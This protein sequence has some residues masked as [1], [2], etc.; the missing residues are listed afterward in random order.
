M[1]I[2]S[3]IPLLV[4]LSLLVSCTPGGESPLTEGNQTTNDYQVDSNYYK[5]AKGKTADE[6]KAALHEIIDDHNE[7]TYREVWEALMVT[8]EDPQNS[9]NVILFYSGRSQDKDLKGPDADDWNREHIWAKS[10]GGFDTEPG[11]GTDLHHLRPTDVSVNASRGNLDF[12]Y[13]GKE[14]QEAKGNYYDYDSFEPRDEVKGDIARMLFY[15]A[16]RYEGGAG[17]LDLE[18][19]DR[20]NNGRTPLH[21]KLSVL[22]EWHKEDPVDENEQRRNQLI[23]EEFQNNRN[24]FIDHP[25]W[26]FAIWGDE[27]KVE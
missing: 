3:F 9:D 2:R 14:H 1:G 22:L 15:M 10:H 23:Y 18:L 5:E 20:V 16:V 17:E 7:L 19:N 27:N 8:D 21:G 6:L 26:A 25:E 24:P 4:L 13:G 12:D 11:V